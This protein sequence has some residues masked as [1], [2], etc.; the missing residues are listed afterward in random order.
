MSAYTSFILDANGTVPLRYNPNITKPSKIS[1][2]SNGITAVTT[3]STTTSSLTD[4][5]SLLVVGATTL[6]GSLGVAGSTTFASLPTCTATPT[7]AT[8]LVPKQFIDASFSV[9]NNTI[10]K[11]AYYTSGDYTVISSNFTVGPDTNLLSTYFYGTTAFLFKSTF[12]NWLPT[13]TLAANM[14]TDVKQFVHKLYCDSFY[15][16]LVSPTFTGTSTMGATNFNQ[17]YPTTTLAV[18]LINSVAQFITKGFADATYAAL[19][20][21]VNFVSTVYF[22][23]TP[24]VNIGTAISLNNQ[25]VHKGYTDT[26]YAKLGGGV[27]AAFTGSISSTGTVSASVLAG[28]NIMESLVNVSV[29]GGIAVC[30]YTSGGIFYV[31]GQTANFI[32]NL[33]LVPAPVAGVYGNVYTITLIIDASLFKFYASTVKINNTTTTPVVWVSPPS[34]GSGTTI[35]QTMS[36]VWLYGAANAAKCICTYAQC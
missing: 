3:T 14:V 7:S 36:I 6:S 33:A 9:I 26:I 16:P 23:I 10:S 32:V 15:A 2:A 27:G 29:T 11:I 31:Q 17:S 34:I 30:S 22:G 18:G 25:L 8:Q 12:N 13:T 20:A 28:N 24:T 5:G 4:N 35:I 1:S 19:N 21:P